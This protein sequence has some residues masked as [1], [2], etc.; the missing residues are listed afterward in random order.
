MAPLPVIHSFHWEEETKVP[1]A[2]GYV[3]VDTV[4][5]GMRNKKE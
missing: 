4:G 5:T 2:T 1:Y 3:R